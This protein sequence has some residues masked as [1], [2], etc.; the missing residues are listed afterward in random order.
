MPEQIPCRVCEKGT[1]QQ[2]K[3]H[4]MSS[5][6]VAIGYILLIP[7]A[8]G[9]LLSLGFILLSWFSSAAVVSSTNAAVSVHHLPPAVV[10]NLQ[11][12]K[13]PP[14]M[15]N[16]LQAGKDIDASKEAALSASQREAIQSAQTEM[17]AAEEIGKAGARS[18]AGCLGGC[19]SIL[20]IIGIVFSFVGG[21]LGWILIMKKTVLKCGS[22]G[23]VV[24]AS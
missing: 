5:P 22:C 1:L 11:I 10:A 15:I 3:V 13:I 14:E 2:A 23:A 20:G 12:E 4:R 7:S 24:A 19:G 9:M 21:L 17:K 18:A 6:V 16:D 8:I